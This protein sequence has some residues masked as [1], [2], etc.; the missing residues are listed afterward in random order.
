MKISLFV[1][2]YVFFTSSS[3]VDQRFDLVSLLS[4][5]PQL[6]KSPWFLSSMLKSAHAFELSNDS[7]SD[8]SFDEDERHWR[9]STILHELLRLQPNNLKWMYKSIP[10]AESGPQREELLQRMINQDPNHW[11][12]TLQ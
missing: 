12:S 3:N 11:R 9:S 10:E 6:S 1:P 2:L 8:D 5:A 7:S 4:K